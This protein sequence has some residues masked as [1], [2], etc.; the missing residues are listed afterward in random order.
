MDKSSFVQEMAWHYTGHTSLALSMKARSTDAY[1]RN[2]AS[3]S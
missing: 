1:M 2:F 3:M